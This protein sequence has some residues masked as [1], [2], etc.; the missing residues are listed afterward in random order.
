MVAPSL[1]RLP[2]S[3]GTRHRHTDVGWLKVRVAMIMQMLKRAAE[4]GP[5]SN[6]VP[7]EGGDDGLQ[8]R[9]QMQGS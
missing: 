4:L 8:R 2:R 7:S 9:R 5:V 6:G 1:L 3:M